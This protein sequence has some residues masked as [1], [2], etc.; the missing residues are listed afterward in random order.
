MIDLLLTY[1]SFSMQILHHYYLT[2][3]SSVRPETT[4]L[5][6]IPPYNSSGGQPG[7]ND[8]GDGT[9]EWVSAGCAV[10]NVL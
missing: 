6:V 1:F 9:L 4:D 2:P 3:T 10:V 8:R 5:D 7:A